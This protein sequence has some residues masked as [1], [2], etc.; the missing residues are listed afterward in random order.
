[1]LQ[2]GQS[3]SLSVSTRLFG[4]LRHVGPSSETEGSPLAGQVTRIPLMNM[5][6]FSLPLES[7][8]IVGAGS[9]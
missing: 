5:V 2:R 3:K 6:C 8:A 7:R 4:H 9:L 1:M